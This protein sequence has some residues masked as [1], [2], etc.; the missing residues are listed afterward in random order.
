M[1]NYEGFDFPDDL[2]YTEDQIWVKKEDG[3]VRLGF[4]TFAKLSPQ[5]VALALWNQASGLVQ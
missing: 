2:Y 4:T 5:V 3:K 1:V